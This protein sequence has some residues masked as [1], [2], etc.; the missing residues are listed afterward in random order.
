MNIDPRLNE[1]VGGGIP[2]TPPF[3]P[4]D[5]SPI[6]PQ[7]IP[8]F[9][10]DPIGPIDPNYVNP[11]WLYR[12]KA[13]GFLGINP[14]DFPNWTGGAITEENFGEFLVYLQAYYGFL[15][16]I[17][18]PAHLSDSELYAA[19]QALLR[20]YPDLDS[21]SIARM[22]M[23]LYYIGGPEGFRGEMYYDSEGNPT[24][25]YGFTRNAAG[26]QEA[27]DYI[28]ATYGTNYTLDGLF[29]GGQTLTREYAG[30]ILGI[31][32]AKYYDLV[33]K[34]LEKRGIT[35]DRDDYNRIFQILFSLVYQGGAGFFDKFPKFMKALLER[36]YLD[37]WLQLVYKDGTPES[38]I[39]DWFDQTR[40][41]S[42]RFKMFYRFFSWLFVIYG[43]YPG[44]PGVGQKPP[45]PG[46]PGGEQVV[47]LPPP[48]VIDEPVYDPDWLAK[49]YN[50][51]Y[52]PLIE[53][54]KHFNKISHKGLR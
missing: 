49:Q 54:F 18:H 31:I 7:G 20:N 9:T 45:I 39:S 23:F 46:V 15:V 43:I 1:E 53:S 6:D 37:A 11:K 8:E 16:R 2:P 42:P 52:N 19:L 28:N 35:S 50:E 14:D 33:A 3:D 47:N 17:D 51:S 13:Q 4:S 38:K 10:P 36:R 24:I 30:I 5:L 41:T 34:G 21:Q 29:G 27:L 12:D 22:I 44:G 32:S 48:E 25:G 40:P 26:L